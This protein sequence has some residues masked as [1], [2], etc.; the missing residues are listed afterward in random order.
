MTDNPKKIAAILTAEGLSGSSVSAEILGSSVSAEIG[1]SAGIAGNS[2]GRG[3]DRLVQVTVTPDPELRKTLSGVGIVPEAQAL[4]ILRAMSR[5]FLE[6]ECGGRLLWA[7]PDP[8]GP[9]LRA[10]FWGSALDGFDEVAKAGKAKELRAG[11]DARY[12]EY[13]SSRGLAC[14]ARSPR[15]SE[16][17]VRRYGRLSAPRTG[18]ETDLSE[19]GDLSLDEDR[20][21]DS[22]ISGGGKGRGDRGRAGVGGACLVMPGCAS[23]DREGPGCARSDRRE[24]GDADSGRGG[25]WFRKRKAGSSR[26]HEEFM[27]LMERLSVFEVENERLRDAL[28]RRMRILAS[29]DRYGTLVRNRAGQILEPGP[30]RVLEELFGADPVNSPDD[31]PADLRGA[32]SGAVI[33]T[34]PGS[35]SETG[36]ASALQHRS[37]SGGRACQGERFWKLPGGRV[38][39]VSGHCWSEPRTGV[40]DTGSLSLVAELSGHGSVWSALSE[41]CGAFGEVEASRALA[42]SYAVGGEGV[43]DRASG[44][45]PMRPAVCE[46]AW[47]WARDFLTSAIGAGAELCDALHGE[48]VLASDR[49]GSALFVCEG[50]RGAFRMGFPGASGPW[51]VRHPRASAM[52]FVIE[53]DGPRAVVTGCPGRALLAKAEDTGARVLVL[54]ERSDPVFLLPHMVARDVILTGDLRLKPL[55]RVA[56]F[57]AGK[58]LAFTH[59]KSVATAAVPP[60]ARGKGTAP[61]CGKVGASAY[62]NGAAPA[63]VKSAA[64]A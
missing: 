47:G 3:R 62:G 40:S 54:G 43:L 58:M 31:C 35:P 59:V 39:R 32:S 29:A 1:G 7:I 17:E 2:G 22:D 13:L 18:P 5:R 38:I 55:A 30:G 45:P 20:A 36:P 60:A 42:F 44:E 27:A 41:L 53:G 63:C 10:G 28:E 24:T 50:G 6:R 61:A 46:G 12:A 16:T 33:R 48:G 57:L 56:D 21:G 25:G 14:Q 26:D 23:A 52:P 37:V 9:G 8:D 64:P 51:H 15:P 11:L 19:S 34:S 49:H 4:D